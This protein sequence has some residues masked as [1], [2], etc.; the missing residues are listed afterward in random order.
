MKLRRD[1]KCRWS[2]GACCWP[3]DGISATVFALQRQSSV[4]V[5]GPCT[6]QGGG[7]RCPARSATGPTGDGRA[8]RTKREQSRRGAERMSRERKGDER[9]KTTARRRTTRAPRRARRHGGERLLVAVTPRQNRSA[10]H[11]MVTQPPERRYIENF[12]GDALNV[13]SEYQ[14]SAQPGRS[15]PSQE[16]SILRAPSP[17]ELSSGVSLAA[18]MTTP[19]YSAGPSTAR[20]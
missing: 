2:G 8:S 20:Y 17:C 16:P 3:A 18:S 19:Y 11:V 10:V 7:R 1:V 14:S 4:P 5:S 12:G 15:C 6:S 13:V 9:D